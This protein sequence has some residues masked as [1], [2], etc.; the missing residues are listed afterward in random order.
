MPDGHRRR[1]CDELRRDML[2]T[3]LISCS[4][5]YPRGGREP[6]GNPKGAAFG[7]MKKKK[8]IEE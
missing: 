3:K 1:N 2:L 4:V 8:K 7:R 6:G 5:S